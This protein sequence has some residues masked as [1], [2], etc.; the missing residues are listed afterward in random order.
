MPV[1]ET[2]ARDF[3]AAFDALV[4]GEIIPI[5][6]P[7][8]QKAEG[9]R[10]ESYFRD[11]GLALDSPLSWAIGQRLGLLDALRGLLSG[12]VPMAQLRV[13]RGEK[14]EQEGWL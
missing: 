5:E 8:E 14:A 7:N 9:A 6:P 12:S 4:L 11:P 3:L 13:W 10:F 1:T 2:S